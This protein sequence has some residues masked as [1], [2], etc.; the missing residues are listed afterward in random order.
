[1]RLVLWGLLIFVLCLPMFFVLLLVSA[2]KYPAMDS[3][4]MSCRWVFAGR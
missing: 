2:A 4:T 3:L 1:M